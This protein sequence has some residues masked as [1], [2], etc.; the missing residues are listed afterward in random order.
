M[1]SEEL[2]EYADKAYLDLLSIQHG[3]PDRLKTQRAMALLRDLIAELTL[4]TAE[5]V[6]N[7]YEAAAYSLAHANQK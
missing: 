2:H 6:Q 3:S 7:A 4:D 1:T 5:N